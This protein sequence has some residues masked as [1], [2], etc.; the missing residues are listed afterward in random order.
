[1]V[2][3]KSQDGTSIK[4]DAD[5]G[6]P[7]PGF[8]LGFPVIQAPYHNSQTGKNSYLLITPSGAHVDL[9]QVGTSNVYEAEDSSSLQLINDGGNLT[10]RPTDGSQFSYT[11]ING[12]YFCYQIKDRN[13]NFITISYQSDGRINTITD[14]LGRIVTF[15]YDAFSNLT[16]ITQQWVVN[17]QTVTHKWATFGWSNQAINTSFN[18][19]TVVGPQ[20]GAS[21]PMLTSFG[22]G[23]GTY[24][25]FSYNSWGQVDKVT[26]YA[27]DSQV[28]GQMLDTHRLTYTSYTLTTGAGQ[29]DC[30]RVT[31]SRVK[32][33]FWNSDQ[34]VVTSYLI[35][36][37]HSSAEVTFPDT[38]IKYKET[39]ATSGW[40][41]GLTTGTEYWAGAVK[42][43]STA[44]T[45]AQNNTS[46][47]YQQNP[48]VTET[49][50]YD[51]E[52]NHKR[53]V[54]E[55]G[56]AGSNYEKWSLPSRVIEYAAD[57]VTEVRHTFTDYYFDPEYINRRIIGLVKAV[58]ISDTH[59]W[60]SIV[61][62]AYDAGGNQ[63]TATPLT[64]IQHDAS[65]DTSTTAKWRGN[66]TT[67]TRYDVQDIDNVSKRA[68]TQ[69]GYDANGSVIFTRDPL[70]QSGQPGH[71]VNISYADSFSD[72]TKNSLNTYAY[73]TKV[74]PP[75]AGQ[76]SEASFSSTSQ[77]DYYMGAVTRTQ[78]AVP[79]GQTQGPVQTFEYDSAGRISRINNLVNNAYQRWVYDPAGHVSAYSLVQA[80][81]QETFTTT[82]FDGM[83]RV[84]GTSGDNPNST[85]GYRGQLIQYDVMGRVLKQSNPAEMNAAWVPVG[86]DA[87][88]LVYTQQAYDW[89]G[90]PTVTINPDGTTKEVSYGGCGC[91]GGEVVTMRDEMGRQQ[92][93]TSDVL[94]R[95]WKIEQLD[96][97]PSQTVYS[98]TTNTYNARDQITS[99]YQA[100]GSGAGQT[101]TL[102]Y[103]GHGRLKTQQTP[104]QIASN[105]VTTYAYNNDDSVQSVTDGRGAVTA[106]TYNS[107]QQIMNIAYS[108]PSGIIDPADVN[109]TYD[110]AGNRTSMS[111]G[112]GSVSYV[113]DQ[114]SRLTSESR[115]FNGLSGTYTLSY[116]Y[117]LANQLLSITDATGASIS[118]AYDKTGRMTDV[119]GSG[120]ANVT[121][122]ASN[123]RYRAWGGMKSMAYGNG[124]NLATSYNSR[125]Q[126]ASFEVAGRPPQY[127]AS[128]VISTQY[129][130]HADGN[131]RSAHD[132][133]DERMDRAYRYDHIGRLQEAY[134]GSE[135]RDYLNN[136]QSGM[137]TGPYRQ[138]YQY[139]VWGELT[140]RANRFWNQPSNFTATYINGRNQNPLWQFDNDG[141]LLLDDTLYYTYDAA[142][143]N[144]QIGT[145]DG[146]RVTTQ[147]RDG[148]GQT[149]KRVEQQPDNLQPIL[150]AYY[151]RSSVLGGRVITELSPMGEKTKGYVY[152]GG[153]VLAHQEHNLVTWQH[154]TPL[155]G[156]RGESRMDGAYVT[157]MEAD[158]VGVNVGVED[159]FVDPL[160][161][162]FEP[163]SES[164]MIDGL[165]GGGGCSSSNPNCHKC[166]FNGFEINCEHV[167]FM[168]DIGVAEI[169]AARSP[170]ALNLAGV[171]PVYGGDCVTVTATGR[172]ETECRNYVTGYH[173]L[174]SVATNINTRPLLPQQTPIE[175]LNTEGNTAFEQNKDTILALISRMSDPN[176]PCAAAFKRAGLPTPG[177]IVNKGLILG[178][179]RA[180]TDAAYNGVLGLTDAARKE[181][182]QSG[183]N[184][185][186][187]LDSTRGKPIILFSGGTFVDKRYLEDVP[188]EF[189]HAAG[190]RVW[191]FVIGKDVGDIIPFLKRGHDL[192]HFPPYKDIISNCE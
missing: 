8:R 122:Y 32:A 100:G 31:D 144:Q 62:Y 114:L 53:T 71:E 183:A 84:R 2:W 23:D 54:I 78:G 75:L 189:I 79:A 188:H 45:F 90:R 73:P 14:T 155:V 57:G 120:Y 67:V 148:T 33:E 5:R 38:N 43:K 65:Y 162:G 174:G 171:V 113:Y 101:T 102:T 145:M 153:E 10:L 76:E 15:V 16:E 28:N 88:G 48:R 61:Y 13:G 108:A 41:R 96:W 83:G 3:T 35:A 135:A 6:T 12:Q 4:F 184:A 133:L 191:R 187:I 118:Y 59:I 190:I 55:Y 56:T 185:V 180:L 115:Q 130:Y 30:P 160:P 72:P 7:S 69:I 178:S 127:G 34:E 112:S 99:V 116:G 109:L 97:Y 150:T 140:Q 89:K 37:D 82:I 103:D 86:D 20:N 138:S 175:I 52:G 141:R 68:V 125:L 80:G 192:I 126:L 87:S 29:T 172:V 47:N 152:A 139:D 94:G 149:V 70:W 154:T 18:G 182:N 93:V 129:Q 163:T 39:F 11:L 110:A 157:T 123:L 166:F 121:N 66:L 106:F 24:Y 158:P 177:E 36:S 26:A 42:K 9:R 169:D 51:I 17:G 64:T 136:T 49:N 63:L 25:K 161:E 170:G 131:L 98:T 167:G 19:L 111:D 21:I 181:Y 134:T 92:R 186:T 91:A 50:V 27:A 46:L 81:G 44:T 179:R 156:S 147:E 60:E 143:R 168:V 105:A 85:G 22:L 176:G 58:H 74:T 40:Q 107:R 1:L 77:Y 95:T 128:T 137:Q 119:N 146:T 164:P 142:G 104:L 151:L 124:L 173:P 117:N 132:V 159:P 165:G